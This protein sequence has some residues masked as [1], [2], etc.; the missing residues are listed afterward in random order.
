[1]TNAKHPLVSIGIPTFNRAGRHLGTVI[2]RALA[3]TYKNIEVIVSDN[4][5][6]DN[7]PDLVQSIKDPGYAIFAKDQ[8]WRQQQLQLL[9]EPGKR[10]V[11]PA[12]P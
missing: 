12:F 9:S 10:R 4:C 3:Q 2:E 8:Y 5:S 11:L 6:T 7:T 1:M